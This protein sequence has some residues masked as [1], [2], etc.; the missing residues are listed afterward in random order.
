MWL[1][2]PLGFC[3]GSSALQSWLGFLLVPECSPL[4]G[5]LQLLMAVGSLE[6]VR[7]SWQRVARECVRKE[8]GGESH[9]FE[10][11]KCQILSERQK[12]DN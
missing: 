3:G 6:H 2:E 11:V 10:G 12:K 1:G 7:G 4:V 9:I 8:K 5:D